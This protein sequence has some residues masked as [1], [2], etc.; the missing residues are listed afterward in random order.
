MK[1][2]DL[3]REL[4]EFDP[5]LEV[6]ITDGYRFNFYNTKALAIVD[7]EIEPGLRVLDIGVGDCWTEVD[8]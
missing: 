8:N 7:L 1:V 5:D 3:I 4:S 6:T 2:A